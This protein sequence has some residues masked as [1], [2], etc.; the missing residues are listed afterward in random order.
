M[1]GRNGYLRKKKRR[2]NMNKRGL[3]NWALWIG[4]ISGIYCAVYALTLLP[5]TSNHL[6]A[7]CNV[8]CATFT[9]LPIYFNGGA[10]REEFFKYCGSYWVGIAW[11]ILYLFIIDRLTAAGVPVWLNFGLVVGIVCTVECGIHF[12]LPE[13]LPFN[14]IPAHFGAISSSFWCAALTILATGEAGRT[15]IGGCYNLKAFPILGV[16]LCTGALL[17]LVCNEGLH[18]IDPETGRWKRPAGRKKVSVKQMQVDFMDE[19]E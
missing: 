2:V 7:G 18:L 17:G 15:S 13:N 14:V 11:A 4:V 10:K 3:L 9:A 1:T 6:L 12:I 16:T 8:M 5:F 19:A